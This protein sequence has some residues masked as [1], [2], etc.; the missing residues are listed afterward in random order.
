[1]SLEQ[2]RAVYGVV[3]TGEGEGDAL[4]VDHSETRAL[5][6]VLASGRV[7]RE[8]GAAAVFVPTA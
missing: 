8:I 7:D 5:R 3:F 4:A 1:V 6:G 2:A